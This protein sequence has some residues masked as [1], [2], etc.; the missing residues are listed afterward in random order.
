MLSVLYNHFAKMVSETWRRARSSG[1]RS[2][3]VCAKTHLLNTWI[4]LQNRCGSEQVACPCCGWR[5]SKFFSLDCGWFIV[6]QVACPACNAHER[7]RM[8]HLFFTRRPPAFLTQDRPGRILH[9]APEQQVRSF[10]EQNPNLTTLCTDY[11]RFMVARMPRPGFVADIHRLPLRDHVIDGLYCM[12]VLEHVADDR[13]AI[14]EL[15]RVLKPGGE[16]LI[17]VPFMMDQTETE[18]YGAPDP[19]I[20]DHVRGYSPLDFKDR[21]APFDYEEI[22]PAALMNPEEILRYRVPDSQVIYLCKKI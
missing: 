15:H 21:L 9:F 7:H 19:D 3:W 11:A 17:M 16:A 1:W 6:P 14:R 12:H 4:R 8:L 5:G 18:E 2:G 22:M 13:H 10:T 20:F